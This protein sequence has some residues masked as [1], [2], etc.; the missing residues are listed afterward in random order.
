[1]DFLS[2]ASAY[3]P[4]LPFGRLPPPFDSLVGKLDKRRR[5]I[6]VVAVSGADLIGS[7]AVPSKSIIL[8]LDAIFLEESYFRI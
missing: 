1:M 8:K 2:R 4:S 5:T 3:L 7:V 6:A